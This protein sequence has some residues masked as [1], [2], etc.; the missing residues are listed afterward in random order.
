MIIRFAPTIFG[1]TFPIFHI[2]FGKR[3]ETRV[4]LLLAP[5]RGRIYDITLDEAHVG[6]GLFGAYFYS[7]RLCITGMRWPS[8]GLAIRRSEVGLN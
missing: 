3:K 2:E 1:R 8:R 7:G 4:W 5:W 6:W